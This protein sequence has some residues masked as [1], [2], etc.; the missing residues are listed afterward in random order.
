MKT[1]VLSRR[2]RLQRQ[3][4]VAL[5]VLIAAPLPLAANEAASAVDDAPVARKVERQIRFAEIGEQAG[6][7]IVHSTRSFGDR[8]KAEVLEMFTDGGAAAAVGDYNND[9]RDDIF[10]V[11][12]DVGKPHSL[13]RNDG[14]GPDGVVRFTNVG[15]Q[16]GVTGGNDPLS[17]CGDA[18]WFDYD[19]DGWLDLLVGRF[20]TPL[21][22]RNEGPVGQ[23]GEHRFTNVSTETGLTEFGNTIAMI[24]FDHDN[25]GWLDLL[26][27]NYFKPLNLLDLDT[28]HVLP[29][30]LDYADNGG[31]VTFWHNVSG[32]KGGRRFVEITKAA[33]FS[34]HTGWSLDLG[35]ADLDNDGLQDVYIAGDYGTDRL[36]INRG[37]AQPRG[38]AQGEASHFIFEDVTEEAMGFDTRKGMNV[39]MGDY[40]RDGF[41][42]V[43]VT[44]ITDEY[45]KE[46][47]FLWHNNG[48][49]TLIDLSRETGTC[50]TDWGWA[51]KFGDFDN[52]GWED[53]F[54]VDGLRSGS[55][56]NFI[57]ILLQ[58]IITPGVDFSDVNSYP[59]IGEMTW[60][61][62]QKQRFFHNL[63][64]GTFKETAAE[65]GLD[66]DLDGR[67]IGMADFDNDG[68][69][70][71]YQTNANQP[72]LL[73]HNRS[74]GAGN[75]VQL[76]L[77]GTQSNRD[78]IGARVTI[79]AGG[80]TYLREVNGGNAYS[81]QS[82]LR[83]HFGLGQ[84]QRVDSV[85]IRWPGG[86]V[87]KLAAKEGEPPLPINALTRIKEGEGVVQ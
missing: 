41:L 38:Q 37:R 26:L 42:D 22:Y 32:E 58:T 78:A 52:D 48:D 40:N 83:L 20:G 6:V 67:G 55:E 1:S 34:H 76:K 85:E 47:N 43:Y 21:L 27:G 36:F 87:E 50:D 28:P 63:G 10:V 72:A 51:A 24:A 29:N 53:I 80:E 71:L 23:G 61:G 56:E 59:D 86:A 7:R 30:N 66:N 77:T 65:V 5:A 18:L 19:N 57:P 25:D 14:V 74:K 82:T 70:D 2:E 9:G 45:M 17:I 13:M 79:T 62:Y 60:S 46:C 54:A 33:G 35:H 73:H 12:S 39:D 16:A 4:L 84:A 81:S 49:G 31:G 64:D 11:D 69:L 75:W 3:T 15:P 8:H 44:N 68:L